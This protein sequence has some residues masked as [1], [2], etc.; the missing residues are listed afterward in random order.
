MSR[1]ERNRQSAA[2]SR[3]RKKQHIR[4]LERR[5]SLLSAENAHLQLEQLNL[6]K[7]RLEREKQLIEENRRLKNEVRKSLLDLCYVWYSLESTFLG[8]ISGEGYS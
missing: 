1:A 8:K 7:S 6:V 5:V 4:E 3:E 2:A